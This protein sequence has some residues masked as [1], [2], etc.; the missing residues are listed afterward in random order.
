MV[1]YDMIRR[2]PRGARRRKAFNPLDFEYVEHSDE[3]S[4]EEGVR[5][6]GYDPISNPSHS[7]HPENN[8]S[9][10]EVSFRGMMQVLKRCLNHPTDLVLAFDCSGNSQTSQQNQQVWDVLFPAVEKLLTVEPTVRRFGL[11]VTGGTSELAFPL[12][13]LG[14]KDDTKQHLLAQWQ[15]LRNFGVSPLSSLALAVDIVGHGRFLAVKTFSFQSRNDLY[16]LIINNWSSA[17]VEADSLPTASEG[18]TS[19]DTIQKSHVSSDDES[20]DESKYDM[21][22][23]DDDGESWKDVGSDDFLDH[24]SAH[25]SWDDVS[26]VSSVMSLDNTQNLYSYA[27][28][29]RFGAKRNSREIPKAL[30][31]LSVPDV[32][33]KTSDLEN[34]LP[35]II[36]DSVCFVLNDHDLRQQFLDLQESFDELLDHRME[37]AASPDAY[38]AKYERRGRM[39]GTRPDGAFR[40]KRF[41]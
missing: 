6:G 9:F 21:V 16:G 13:S 20:L 25:E 37:P 23:Y 33:S 24:A 30:R 4:D 7:S 19:E 29:V 35:S 10:Q 36:E 12:Q 39:G 15:E 5:Y 22:P 1:R 34:P 40:W 3:R 31:H 32:G 41:K 2:P 18:C 14:T 27:D 28:M 17:H 38:D 26:D 8:I 11:Y